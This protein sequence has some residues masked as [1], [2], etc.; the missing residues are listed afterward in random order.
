MTIL[1][2]LTMAVAA[3]MLALVPVAVQA[4]TRASSSPVSITL[5]RGQA[6][7]ADGTDVAAHRMK[8]GWLIIVLALATAAA[9]A[10]G[11]GGKKTD[12]RSRG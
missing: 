10:A 2:R 3:S 12:T 9:A 11:G 4:G 7:T 1:P 6:G 5:P 8:L